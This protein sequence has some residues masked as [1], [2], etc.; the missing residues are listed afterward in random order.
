[1]ADLRS[2]WRVKVESVKLRAESIELR[3]GG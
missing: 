1:M 3:A 2:E